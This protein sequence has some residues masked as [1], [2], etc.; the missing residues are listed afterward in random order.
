MRF[1]DKELKTY[2]KRPWEGESI[3]SLTSVVVSSF[4]THHTPQPT[5]SLEES[6]S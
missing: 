4:N 5:I 1:E 2:S 3:L 6:P